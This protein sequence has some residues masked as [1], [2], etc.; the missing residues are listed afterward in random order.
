[1]NT[2]SI[3]RSITKASG[4]FDIAIKAIEQPSHYTPEQLEEEC[5]KAIV[6][7]QGELLKLN[8][9]KNVGEELNYLKD[10]SFESFRYTFCTP[11][12]C[13]YIPCMPA[14]FKRLMKQFDAWAINEI[15]CFD[16]DDVLANLI[17]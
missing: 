5:K 17:N 12:A 15:V 6:F 11:G 14:I 3:V 2:K 7:I 13:S 1:M 10:V 8:D 16:S 9:T 4:L